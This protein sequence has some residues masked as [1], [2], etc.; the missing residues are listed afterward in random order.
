MMLTS[1][2]RMPEPEWYHTTLVHSLVALRKFIIRNF[3]LPR[4][5]FMRERFLSEG[6][7]PKTGRY[8]QSL[9]V[10]FPW[11]VKPTLSSRWGFSALQTRLIGGIL[12]GDE[13]DKYFPQGWKMNEVGPDGMQGKGTAEMAK[14]KQEILAMRGCPMGFKSKGMV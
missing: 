12:P 1:L 13:G 11:Y 10:V 9:Y 4:P 2:L 8:T 5:Y 6:P 3:H 7:D 14:Y